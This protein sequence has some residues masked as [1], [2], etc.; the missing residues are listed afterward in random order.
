MV[1]APLTDM[2]KDSTTDP[3]LDDHTMVLANHSPEGPGGHLARH[4]VHAIHQ[5]TYAD[6]RMVTDERRLPFADPSSV[7]GM[8]LAHTSDK[9]WAT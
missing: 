3:A 8:H 7:T 6:P 4:T 2:P 9:E 5:T 1:H